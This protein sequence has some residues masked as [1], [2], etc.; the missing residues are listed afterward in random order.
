LIRDN[1]QAIADSERCDFDALAIAF[2]R[3]A[4][5]EFAFSD[6]ADGN[7]QADHCGVYRSEGAAQDC[8][9]RP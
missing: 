2:H 8:H 4:D 6:L 5:V 1:F 3:G 7:L 9:F